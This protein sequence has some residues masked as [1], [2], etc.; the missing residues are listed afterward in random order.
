M[1]RAS[2]ANAILRRQAARDATLE[3]LVAQAYT[4]F[5]IAH[6]LRSARL[7]AGVTQAELAERAGT[8]RSVISRLENADYTGHSVQMLR[9]IA[10]AL[11]QRLELRLSPDVQAVESAIRS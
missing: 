2:D 7:A 1:P 5:H 9:R 6:M 8:T 3:P 4:Q 10:S 11:G